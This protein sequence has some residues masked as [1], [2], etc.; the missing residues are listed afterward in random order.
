MHG[1]YL[2]DF[3]RNRVFEKTFGHPTAC[4][5]DAGPWILQ[6]VS[7]ITGT[8][9]YSNNDEVAISVTCAVGRAKC[10]STH[11]YSYRIGSIKELFM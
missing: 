2:I 8:H 3:L 5:L 4:P 7:L 9:T 11:P 1:R 6:D 10:P